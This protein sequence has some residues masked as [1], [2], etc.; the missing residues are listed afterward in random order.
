M[1]LALILALAAAPP[2]AAPPFDP[3]AGSRAACVGGQCEDRLSEPNLAGPDGSC[4]LSIDGPGHATVFVRNRPG[5]PRLEIDWRAPAD[6]AASRVA[7]GTPDLQDPGSHLYLMFYVRGPRPEVLPAAP[8]LERVTLGVSFGPDAPPALAGPSPRLALVAAGRTFGPW[9][10]GVETYRAA[11]A[12]KPLPGRA[13]PEARASAED[14]AAM[15]AA[16]RAGPATIVLFDTA[17]RRIAE[18]RLTSA[19][20]AA[21]VEKAVIWARFAERV[22]ARGRCPKEPD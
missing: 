2:R 12:L 16:V 21:D 9:P 4:G 14:M 17:G 19:P 18:A 7:M 11:V 10:A 22:L 13:V 15:L 5:E 8:P 1:S 3:R 20:Q 6:L